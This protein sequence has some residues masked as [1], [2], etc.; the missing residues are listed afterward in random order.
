L[1]T[2]LLIP[3]ALLV[4]LVTLPRV[5]AQT[6]AD[7]VLR[8]GTVYTVSDRQP[9]AEAVAVTGDRIVFVGSTADAG[10]LVGPRTRLVELRSRVVVPGLTDS[11]YHLL[12]V[13]KREINA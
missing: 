3:V 12:K 4:A 9:T 10:R 13:G 8:G 2:A 5:Q 11:H 6:P 7:L 1:L